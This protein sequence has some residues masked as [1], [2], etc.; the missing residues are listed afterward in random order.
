MEV[1][2]HEHKGKKVPA[3]ALTSLPQNLSEGDLGPLALKD[4][5]SIIA[6]VEDVVEA[7]RRLDAILSGHQT[8][9]LSSDW[10]I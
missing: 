6:S 9:M 8:R 5:G 2:A 7:V 4:D 3:E 10:Q 1:V